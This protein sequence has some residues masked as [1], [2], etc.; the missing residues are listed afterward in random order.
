MKVEYQINNMKEK[1]GFLSYKRI[2]CSKEEVKRLNKLESDGQPLPNDIVRG[3]TIGTFYRLELV[4][5]GRSDELHDFL[6]LKQTLFL[7]TIKN[8]VLFFTVVSII[9]LILT[10]VLK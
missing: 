2:N 7:K 6:L 1:V 4:D 5:E 9:S 3:E 10:L 8:C